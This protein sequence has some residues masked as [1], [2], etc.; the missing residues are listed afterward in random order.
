[1]PL[2]PL[3]PHSQKLEKP[4]DLMAPKR[5][6]R[7]VGS[8][9]VRKTTTKKVVQEIINVT[10]GVFDP[11]STEE[12]VEE[13]NDS[14]PTPTTKNV[15]EVEG[16]S[17]TS[18]TTPQEQE[19]DTKESTPHP[20]EEEN[21]TAESAPHP[22][23]EENDTTESIPPQVENP[24]PPTTTTTIE[25]KVNKEEAKEKK[26]KEKRKKR[27]KEGV[28]VG[29]KRYVFMVLKQV[30]LGMGISPNAMTVLNGL[31]NDA[32][33]HD[34]AP[35][36]QEEEND[37][38]ESIPPQVENPPPPTTTTTIEEKVN[39]EEAKEKKEKEKRKKRRKE[40]VEVGFKRYVFMVLKQVHL[41][42]GISPNAMTVLNGLMNDAQYHDSAPHPQEEENDTTESI[43][44]QVENPPPPTTTTTIE[45]KVNKEEAK[46]KK[47]KEK[48]KKRRKEGVEVGFKRYVFMVLKQVHLGMGI[49]PNAMTVL[50][51]LMNDAQ[52]HDSAPHPQEEENDTTESIPPQV[53]NPPPPTTTTTIEEKVNK[54]EAKEKKEKEKE[55]RK[56]GRKEGVEVGFK[57][58]VFMVLKQVH[59]GMGISP[60]AMTVLNGLMNDMFE[61]LAAEASKLC[62]Y[63]K[64]ATMTSREI[65]GA[66]RLVLPGELGKHASAEGTKAVTN[67]M[68]NDR[69]TS[70]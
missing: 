48:R 36:P 49:S 26:E 29:F 64:R 31:M 18:V 67:Y 19:N 15:I 22:Q 32:Q 6:V 60:N 57:R 61:K 46:E 12:E 39:K 13:L 68:T 45:E 41:G 50:N 21:D 69:A 2:T 63:T 23:E 55:K 4:K 42:M 59:L 52:C 9:F 33:Y 11:N 3:P 16:P 7:V 5:S 25:E 1:M 28:E 62:L 66:V 24:P 14:P 58:Y 54:E 27:R 37:T 56:K 30:H 38:T 65:Q 34:S 51:G 20:Q 40:G 35:H 10:A 43:P 8:S 17:Q 44:P 70:S 47:E 53:E